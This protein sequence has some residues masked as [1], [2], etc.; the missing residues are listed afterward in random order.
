[1]KKLLFLCVL[2]LLLVPLVSSADEVN[3]AQEEVFKAKVINV[4]EEKTMADDTG[5]E[6]VQQRINLKGLEGE[7]QDKEVEFDGISDIIVDSQNLY[8]E[9]DKVHVSYAPSVDGQDHYYILDYSRTNKLYWLAGIFVVLIIAIGRF[10]GVRALVSLIISFAVIMFFIIPRI[11]AGDSPLLI[12]IVGSLAILVV[13]IYLTEGINRRSHTAVISIIFALLIT[14]GLSVLFTWMTRLTG[15]ASEETVYLIGMVDQVINFKGLLL[16]GVLIGTL[17]VLDDV[18]ISQV[19]IVERIKKA[20]PSLPK[21]EVFKRSFKVGISHLSS[22]VNTLFLAYAGASLPLL[23]LFKINQAPFV[24]WSQALNHEAIAT[25][26]V[27]TLT[28]SIGL[29]LAV[30]IATLV[31]VVYLKTKNPEP[32]TENQE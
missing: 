24:T 26:I 28:G 6:V 2:T 9:G 29:A 1:M 23:I 5:R 3:V 32:G 16:A 17:G 21:L 30:P 20:N 11:L 31:A 8:K 4:L 19:A 14:G 13:I 25:E 10:K 12:A 22:M 7:W 15:F 18:V 27:R